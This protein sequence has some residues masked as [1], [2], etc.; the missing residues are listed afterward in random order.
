MRPWNTQRLKERGPAE[1]VSV[2]D[3][4]RRRIQLPP[5]SPP[6]VTARSNRAM[7]R[8]GDRPVDVEHRVAL[9][10]RLR[11]HRQVAHPPGA[12]RAARPC[13]SIGWTCSVADDEHGI[14][15]AALAVVARHALHDEELVAALAAGGLDD[16][17]ELAR[18]RLRWRR[19]V[20][21]VPRRCTTTSRR[22][23]PRTQGPGL[24]GSAGISGSP[25]RRT[26]LGGR[27]SGRRL[28]WPRSGAPSRASVD[29][30]AHRW[31][32]SVG[33]LVSCT[34]VRRGMAQ[35]RSGARS[36]AATS[37]PAESR[38]GQRPLI[39]DDSNGAGSNHLQHD[40]GER[41]AARQRN[42]DREPGGLAARVRAA[43]RRWRRALAIHQN[44]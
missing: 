41:G 30:S 1:P 28:A 10:G 42:D 16:D 35:P 18:A 14:D 3:D 27:R 25:W 37:A 33:L 29:R 38:W 21:C 22:S 23:A 5:R 2:E 19:A 43:A 4:T 26:R 9:D 39:Q 17:A 20:Q 24:D 7:A 34:C 12:P 13:C 6:N 31:R 15:E 44:A 40:G 11:R 36:L 32:R 8:F